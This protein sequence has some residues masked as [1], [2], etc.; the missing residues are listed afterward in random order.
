[1]YI[2]TKYITINV[3]L[4]ICIKIPLIIKVKILKKYSSPIDNFIETGPIL[5]PMDI[6]IFPLLFFGKILFFILFFI[7][8]SISFSSSFCRRKELLLL[9]FILFWV[10]YI[11]IFLSASFFSKLFFSSSFLSSS[12]FSSTC[13]LL[14]FSS[15]IFLLLSFI[16]LSSCGFTFFGLNSA[17]YI[18]FIKNITIIKYKW[19]IQ[20]SISGYLLFPIANL[21]FLNF[22]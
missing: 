15:S 6:L 11:N 18:E 12:F 9:S 21:L 2:D 20:Y 22:C 3:I 5:T 10:S 4:S 1:M 17:V 14:T 16:S 13:S 7:L 8:F 19:P